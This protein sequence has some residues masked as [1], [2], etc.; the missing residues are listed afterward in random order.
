MKLVNRNE[1]P[2]GSLDDWARLAPPA[3]ANHWKPGRSA[4][5]LA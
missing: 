3:S 1:V 4:Y 5:E 2:I